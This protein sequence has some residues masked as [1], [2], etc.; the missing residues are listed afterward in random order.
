MKTSKISFQFSNIIEFVI[1]VF[2]LNGC[3][4][5]ENPIDSGNDQFVQEIQ[6]IIIQ[7]Q[8]SHYANFEN[9]LLQMDTVQAIDSIANLI[10]LD[11]NVDWVETSAQGIAILYKNGIKG[12]LFIN[13]KD[14]GTTPLSYPRK[15]ISSHELDRLNIEN[16][17]PVYKKVVLI[18][19][20]YS[21]RMTYTEELITK[22]NDWFPEA[23]YETP[24]IYKGSQATLDLFA[25]LSNFG[26]IHIYSHGWAW[27]DENTMT[28][29]YLQTGENWTATQLLNYMEDYKT[30]TVI[31]GA[32]KDG[33]KFY[34]SSKFLINKNNFTDKNTLIYGG[35]CYSFEGQWL[36]DMSAE[37]VGGYF[38]FSWSVYTN[39]NQEWA[40]DLFFVLLDRSSPEPTTVTD[41]LQN[42]F[43]PK[44][45]YDTQDKKDV[46]LWYTGK[47]D[48]ALL[49][50]AE[51]NWPW[52]Y[53]NIVF[54]NVDV[55]CN[56]STGGTYLWDN[57]TFSHPLQYTGILTDGVT[58]VAEWDTVYSGGSTEVGQLSI[59]VDTLTY[60]VTH[61]Q[62]SKYYEYKS[63]GVVTSNQSLEI[64]G[65]NI[66]MV[67]KDEETL[68][69]S[70]EGS[71]SCTAVYHFNFIYTANVGKPTEY[72]YTLDSYNCDELTFISLFWDI[73]K[74]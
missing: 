59:K 28:D 30:N 43:P 21:E 57:L 51:V 55:L 26:V 69:N 65:Q 4:K 42:P 34:I 53:V 18:N 48:L 56:V 52:R 60:M 62:A 9:M 5:E 45:Y 1:V 16:V 66:P 32:S 17:I 33:S 61:F 50:K 49:K 20:H 38:G 25:S 35:F 31:I 10:S 63:G 41:W 46:H 23:G 37:K 40:K 12:G 54:N 7:S 67:W 11:E 27:P 36:F 72:T 73:N 3:T 68:T 6:S 74:W 15:K 39:K 29:V 8:E 2:L 44:Q 71:E 64:E 24:I 14:I 70:I 22:Y 47:S 58:F 19:P 13:P